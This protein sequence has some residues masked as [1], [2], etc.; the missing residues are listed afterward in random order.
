M[1]TKKLINPLHRDEKYKSKKLDLFSV[2]PR[3]RSE[4]W[5][6]VQPANEIQ[7]EIN[8][9]MFDQMERTH[10]FHT[11]FLLSYSAFFLSNQPNKGIVPKNK[12]GKK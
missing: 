9:G 2:H 4:G 8:I 10:F 3:E 7:T 12:K 11:P 6:K 5:K 1:G